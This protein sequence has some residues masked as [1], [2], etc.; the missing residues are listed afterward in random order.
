VTAVVWSE[1]NEP[2]GGGWRD[3][4]Y[5]SGLQAL[6]HGGF[7]KF[8]LGRYTVAEREALERSDD[9]P[10]E[11]GAS[12]D[13]LIVAVKR[14]YGIEWS[15]S[16]TALLEPLHARSDLAFVVQGLNGNLPAG[17][18]LRRWDPTFTG[19]HCVTV[20]PVG[21][22]TNVKWLDP[23]APMLF[24]GDVAAWAT[25]S[26]WMG[27][28]AFCISVRKDAYAPPPPTTYTQAQMDAVTTQLAGCRTAL[29][30]VTADL[31]ASNARIV[32]A[33]TALG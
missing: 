4:T 16:R 5:C 2:A 11:T 7:T 17:H 14:R 23:L 1:R 19:G 30:K 21:D 29:A 32:A 24:T 9:Q 8:P 6:I 15:K 28:S 3:C 10:D 13:D 26:R 12:L 31:A 27:S 18:T 25:V 33:K 20:I 22:G